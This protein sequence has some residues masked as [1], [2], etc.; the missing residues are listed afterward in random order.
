MRVRATR[1]DYW[2]GQTFDQW[3]GQSWVQSTNPAGG[4]HAVKLIGSS[5]FT[6][7][8]QPDQTA[9][10]ASEQEDIQTFYLTTGGSN[11]VF[12]A[13][14]A[15]R[16]Y[17][18]SAS[19]LRHAGRNDH[20]DPVN[21]IRH[22]L[23]RRLERH[24]RHPRTSSRRPLPRAR[25]R[26]RTQ[27]CSPLRTRPVISSCR[28]PY[29]RVAALAA[30]ITR[31]IGHRARRQS[32]DLRQDRSDRAVD[33]HPRPLHHRHPSPA[34]RG[35]CRRLIP[36]RHTTGVL[37]ADLDGD[38]DHAAEP[39]NPGPRGSGI[40]ARPLQ[41]D[42]RSLRRPGQGC[43]RLGPGLVS[44]IWLAEFRPDSHG[45]TGQPD[46]R[47][48]AGP[49]VRER[50]VEASVDSPHRGRGARRRRAAVDAA[51]QPSTGD[52]GASGGGR[53]GTRGHPARMS[54]TS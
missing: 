25:P 6:I 31:G 5:P 24:H 18:R 52:V 44:R 49:F 3:T 22:H 37:R 45:A 13:D 21:G 10:L 40:R 7:P 47:I 48:G 11:L 34:G 53:P 35:R 28:Y 9:Q 50:A 15:E 51:A 19:P 12:H 54:P 29:P 42:H 33:D 1:P 30:S 32:A 2:V 38:G 20:V 23:H 46:A 27:P 14:N 4:V 8:I 17:I 36:L 16:V 43:P 26:Q 41:P 39:G